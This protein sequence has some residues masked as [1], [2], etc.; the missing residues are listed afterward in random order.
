MAEPKGE[1]RRCQHPNCKYRTK[2]RYA[3]AAWCDYTYITGKNRLAGLPKE[4][5]APC[6]CDKYEPGEKVRRSREGIVIAPRKANTY[7]EPREPKA[8]KYASALE[9]LQQAHREGLSDAKIAERLDWPKPRVVYWRKKLGLL[10]NIPQCGTKYDQKLI[11]KLYK[12][13]KNDG[14]IA[15][16]VG[17]SRNNIKNWRLRREQPPNV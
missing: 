4:K 13:G 14:E 9:I 10:S 15:R 2:S 17:C 12:A 6:Y 5:W 8:E 7:S 1:K 11:E 16:A 3:D